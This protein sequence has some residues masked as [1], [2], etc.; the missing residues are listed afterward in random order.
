MQVPAATLSVAPRAT[1]SDESTYL[2]GGSDAVPAART[3]DRSGEISFA[4]LVLSSRAGSRSTSGFN[5]CGTGPHQPVTVESSSRVTF[6][7]APGR[8]SPSTCADPT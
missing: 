8:A 6:T 3:S 4:I 7:P 5:G 1:L 2:P